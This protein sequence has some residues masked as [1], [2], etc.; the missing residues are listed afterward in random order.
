MV[1][2][3]SEFP[4]NIYTFITHGLS[5]ASNIHTHT[6][7][8]YGLSPGSTFSIFYQYYDMYINH[9][10]TWTLFFPYMVLNTN[11]IYSKLI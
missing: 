9:S 1:F 11:N 8:T 3:I 6:L 4:A 2:S 7:L 10:Y 5:E